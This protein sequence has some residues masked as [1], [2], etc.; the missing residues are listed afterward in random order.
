MSE[1]QP[2]A[3]EERV[4]A[5]LDMLSGAAPEQLLEILPKVE[6]AGRGFAGVAQ[7]IFPLLEH[8]DYKVRSRAFITLGRLKDSSI[9]P[10][11]LAY[12]KQEKDEEWRLRVLE[13][14]Y[15]FRNQKVIPDLLP[16][17]EDYRYP[18]LIRGT[19]WLIGSL[20]G[21]EAV[22]IIGEF[23][24]KPHGRIVK[25]EVI[26]EALSLA[27]ASIPDGTSFFA[28]IQKERADIARAFRYVTLPDPEKPRFDVYPYPD[29]L[30]D[31]AKIQGIDAKEFKRLSFWARKL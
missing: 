22:R 7:R 10:E 24:A 21:K 4:A 9:I 30:L 14:L 23:G 13:C 27:I 15:H 11:L 3:L 18:M 17:L 1:S 2:S 31:R 19:I 8:D 12:L 20:G 16:L 5:Y 29:Y 26:L 6:K 25:T 28:K